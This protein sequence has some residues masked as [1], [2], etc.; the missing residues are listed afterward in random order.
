[1]KKLIIQTNGKLFSTPARQKLTL[2]LDGNVIEQAKRLGINISAFLEMRL[3]EFF[4]AHERSYAVDRL[5]A[6]RKNKISCSSE[7]PKDIGKRTARPTSNN[8]TRRRR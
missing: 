8:S 5:L 7:T 3:H 6:D 2:S 1:M 4:E